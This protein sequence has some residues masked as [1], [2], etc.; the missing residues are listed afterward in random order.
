MYGCY[1][2]SLVIIRSCVD[3]EW[4]QWGQW[5]QC[6]VTCGGGGSRVRA[7]EQVREPNDCGSPVEGDVEEY[8]VCNAESPCAPVD[9]TATDCVFGQ[10]HNYDPPEC[11]KTCN[12]GQT[13]TRT[14][15]RYSD[16]GGKPCAGPVK[17]AVRCS[18]GPGQ[19]DP[20]NCTSGIAIDCKLSDWTSWGGCNTACGMG[21]QERGRS[22]LIPPAFGGKDCNS[23]LQESKQKQQQTNINQTTG[24]TTHNKGK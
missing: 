5:S 23:S 12:G 7:R 1:L 14:I 19:V 9:V 10:W 13:R 24:K 2:L 20:P 16:H 11:P 6:S 21:H 8:G 17:E 4:G 3:G 22:V 15:V 18:P